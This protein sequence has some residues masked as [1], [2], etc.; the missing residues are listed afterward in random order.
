[1]LD[2]WEPF[3]TWLSDAQRAERT[4]LVS[5]QR[6]NLEPVEHT[7]VYIHLFKLVTVRIEIKRK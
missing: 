3:L 1:M 5:V 6:M 4:Q 7:C 2:D